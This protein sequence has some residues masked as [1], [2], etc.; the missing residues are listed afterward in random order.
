MEEKKKYTNPETEKLPD[1]SV[2]ELKSMVNTLIDEVSKLKN[3]V[4]GS[5]V[6]RKRTKEHFA[7]LRELE[8]NDKVVGIVTKLYNVKEHKDP[9]ESRRYYATC[10]VNYVNPK[11]GKQETAHNVDWLEFLDKAT[12]VKSQIIKW[13]RT[14]RFEIDPRRGGGGIGTVWKQGPNNEYI[15]DMEFEYE[16][17]YEDHMFTLIITEGT[18]EG[19]TITNDG[20]GLNL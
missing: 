10:S 11:T 4:R 6:I 2:D 7:F 1:L 5:N 12:R 3:P 19:D 17:G 18:F 9:N 8:I 13:D 15:S 14:K 20:S 16:V